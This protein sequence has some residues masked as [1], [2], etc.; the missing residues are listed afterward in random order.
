METLPHL[1]LNGPVAIKVWDVFH[2]I[3]GFVRPNASTFATALSP[4]F[5]KA[6]G[7]IKE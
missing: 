2:N 7:M 3:A 6:R 4:W 1:L 5:N